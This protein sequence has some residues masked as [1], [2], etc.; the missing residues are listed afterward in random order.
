M[1]SGHKN[2]IHVESKNPPIV[3]MDTA[4]HAAYIRFSKDKVFK[5]VVVNVNRCLATMDLTEN[6]TVVGVELAGVKEFGI[7]VLMKKARIQ[8]VSPELLRNTR[9]VPANAEPL[10][11]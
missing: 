4:A 7:D 2:I 9:Y 11:V 10:A 6:G 8:G 3:E 5:T 1:R